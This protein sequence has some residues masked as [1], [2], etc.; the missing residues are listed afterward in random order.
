[1]E[2]GGWTQGE[3]VRR[4]RREEARCGNEGEEHM[5]KPGVN[6]NRDRGSQRGEHRRNLKDTEGHGKS[7]PDTTRHDT[8]T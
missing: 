1:M 8:K 3:Q 5:R 7:K 6:D 2:R 4:E